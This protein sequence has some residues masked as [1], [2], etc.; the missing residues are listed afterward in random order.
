[1]LDAWV[2]MF[3][4]GRALNHSD[5]PLGVMQMQ[6]AFLA[7]AKQSPQVPRSQ[8][9]RGMMRRVSETVKRDGVRRAMTLKR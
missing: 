4:R 5:L 6:G 9:T 7:Q 1:M 8:A 3:A 2:Q